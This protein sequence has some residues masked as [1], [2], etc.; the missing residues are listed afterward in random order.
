MGTGPQGS[1]EFWEREG[2][3]EI[4]MEARQ[5]PAPEVASQAP[6]RLWEGKVDERGVVVARWRP[7]TQG[8]W[9]RGP[10]GLGLTWATGESWPVMKEVFE[11]NGDRRLR[12]MDRWMGDGFWMVDD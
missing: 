12:T 2:L 4:H 3:V 10:G 6:E 9:R 5:S 11:C 1:A 8:L 7:P